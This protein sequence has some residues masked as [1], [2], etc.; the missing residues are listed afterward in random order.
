MNGSEAGGDFVSIEISES[1]I[2]LK[3]CLV[4]EKKRFLSKQDQPLPPLPQTVN[5]LSTQ[6]HKPFVNINFNFLMKN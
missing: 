1:F 5:D 6:I 2:C 3:V 4:F